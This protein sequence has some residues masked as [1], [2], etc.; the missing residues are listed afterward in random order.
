MEIILSLI[1]RFLINRSRRLRIQSV[2]PHLNLRLSVII[3][4][5]IDC[6]FI[7]FFFVF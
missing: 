2:V 1:G 5:I 6:L 7:R 3:I 4:L